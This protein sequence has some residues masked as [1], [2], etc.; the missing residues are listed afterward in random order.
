M[1]FVANKYCNV[2]EPELTIRNLQQ[3]ILQGHF[4]LKRPIMK[5][6]KLINQQLAKSLQNNFS[7]PRMFSHVPHQVFDSCLTGNIQV[8]LHCGRGTSVPLLLILMLDISHK[9]A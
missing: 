2:K 1:L 5:L 7:I 8:I 9:M 3:N 4:S 6:S